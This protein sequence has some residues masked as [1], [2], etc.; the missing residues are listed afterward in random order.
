VLG[1][2]ASVRG[3]PAADALNVALV[4]VGGRGTWFV[5]AMPKMCNVVAFCDVNSQKTAGAFK[6]WQDL[7][8]KFEKSE[9]PWERSAAESYK[10]H[11][12]RKVN[13]YDDFRVMLDRMD[14]QI[15]AVVVAV[16]DHCHG[17]I[18]AA[19]IRA[20]KH[21]FCE[22]PLTR[23]VGESRILR[24]LARKHKVATSMGNQGTASGPFRRS[25]E[26]LQDG[27]L[28]P[29]ETVHVWNTG[30][31]ADR[32]EP[33]KGT[34]P[35]PEGFNW[36]VWLGPMGMRPFHPEWLRRITW[37]DIGTGQLGNWASHSA[38]L[39]FKALQVPSLWLDEPPPDKHPILRVEAKASGINPLSFPKWE[40]IDYQVPARKGLPPIAIH[41]H[42]GPA[43]GSKALI[44]S[45]LEDGKRREQPFAGAV[46]VGKK[47]RLH[48]TGHNA[49]FRL[50]PGKDFKGT[51]VERPEKVDRSRGHEMDWLLACK[52]GKPAWA[53]FEYADALNEF[54]MLGNIATQ[55]QGPIEFDPVDCKI[56]NNEEAD[57]LVHLTCREG[58][59]L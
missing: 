31:G 22:K 7:S 14:K 17:V 5:S 26:L 37:R 18:S 1:N 53:N 48:S 10:R 20:G 57:A 51:N 15:D 44:E 34:P 47:G 21:V 55:V 35:I 36:D 11:L 29:L 39:A 52:G 25:F 12:A 9:H 45:L 2:S 8:A 41:W 40:K 42:N 3:A 13:T 16:T 19:A 54:L 32:T 30:G 6:I 56:V 24:D 50:M 23:T 33:P 4:G 38:N 49:T 43:P 58:W 46:F 27:L 59:A 28:G